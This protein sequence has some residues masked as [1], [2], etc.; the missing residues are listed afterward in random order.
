MAA[1]KSLVDFQLKNAQELIQVLSDEKHAIT[2]R[3]SQEI[4]KCA[5]RKIA[6]INQLQTTDQ[7]IGVHPDIDTL[8]TD[9]EL[10]KTVEKIRLLVDDCKQENLINGEALQRAQLSFNKLNNLMQQTQGKL[11]MTYDAGGQTK[12]VTTLGTN[13]KA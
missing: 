5:H 4:E 7:R 13:L 8:Q 1:L 2:S 6:L 10:A 11:G 12:N 3:N 9:D